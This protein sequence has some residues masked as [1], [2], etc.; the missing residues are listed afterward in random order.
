MTLLPPGYW[1][2]PDKTVSLTQ[3]LT[4]LRVD[5]EA[6]CISMF[7]PEYKSLDALRKLMCLLVLITV[8]CGALSDSVVAGPSITGN[9]IAVL[10]LF[11]VVLALLMLSDEVRWSKYFWITCPMF[12]SLTISRV[13]TPLS[14][15]YFALWPQFVWT[16]TFMLLLIMFQ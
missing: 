11:P 6:V 7:I 4:F 12:V 16:A 13:R 5:I 3:R 14:V 8:V 1:N 15:S 10:E 2:C 9:C